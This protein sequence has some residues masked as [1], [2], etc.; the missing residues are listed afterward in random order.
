MARPPLY[1]WEGTEYSFEEK[2]PDW[3]WAVGIIAVAAIIACILFNNLNLP[4]HVGT[5]AI[6][7]AVQAAPHPRTHPVAI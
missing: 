4:R 7:V 1:E 2:G 6:A 5:A 3:Y